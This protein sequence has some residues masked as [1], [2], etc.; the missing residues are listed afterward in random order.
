MADIAGSNGERKEFIAVGKPNVPGKLSHSIA[1][2][3]AKFGTDVIV[4]NMLHAKFMRSPYAHARVK[5]IDVSKAKAIPGIVE[6]ITCFDPEIKA[7]GG[8]AGMGGAGGGG[9]IDELGAPMLSD[10]AHMEDEEV[11]AIVIAENE[12]ACDEALRKLDI[13]WEQLPFILDP[14]EGKKPEAK[15]IRENKK[16]N[17][18][19][20]NRN[21]GN[22]EYGFKEADQIIEFDWN[23]PYYSSHI[24]NPAGGVAWWYDDPLHSEGE[25]I[26]IEG[27]TQGR[28]H[29][30]ALYKLPLDKVTENTIFQGGKY[31]DWGLRKAVMVTPF[32]S[33]RMGRPVRMVSSRR[34][35]Y[36]LAMNQRF[37]HLKVGFKNDGTITA[38]RDTAVVAAGIP[39]SSNFGTVMDFNYG[40]FF[41]T[42]CTN[43]Q[44]AWEAVYT[45]TGKMYLSAQ[46]CPWTWDSMTVAHQMIAEKLGMDPIDV[47]TKNIHGP[48]A[49]TDTSIPPSYQACV[50]TGKK[51]IK[52]QWHAAG[53]KKLPDGRLHGASF[54]YQM[55]PRHAF[56]GYSCT[57]TVKDDGKVYMPSRGP[58]TGMFAIDAIALVVAEEMGAKIE[59]VI[60]EFDPRAIFTPVGG[61]SDGTTA[62]AWVAKEAAVACKKLLLQTAADSLKV[63][64]EELDTKDTKVIFKSDPN[65]AFPFQQFSGKDLAATFTGRP[66]LSLWSQGMGKLLD[67]MNVLFCEVAVDTETGEVEVL[68]HLIVAD[69]GKV[70][71]RTSLEGQL[72]QVMI[73][74]E[75]NQLKE[76]FYFDK[77]TGVKLHTNMFE[78]KKPTIVDVGPIDSI[79]LE[80]R[81]GNAAYGAN[82]ISH[83]LA[84]THAII[85]AIHNAIGK[86]VDPPATPDR[87]LKALGKA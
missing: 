9:I 22:V 20:A 10:T 41:T 53:A 63:K 52:W 85:C 14:R 71:R 50:E 4:P 16:S 62:A 33:K 44:F 11:G 17:V 39:Y 67:T 76:D 47:A 86:W 87:I 32:L 38:V 6:I 55:C 84:N 18:E 30:A 46:H 26:W 78:Y 48:A 3:K 61:G 66:P 56:S 37:A 28:S 40:P 51:E 70:L 23:L 25:S 58:V 5:S 68:R 43:L 75:G 34:N 73:F 59:D 69:P 81:A 15:I 35:M 79:L 2:G 82:G 65:K 80:T 42:K 49:Q 45:N 27:A 57:V 29:I 54:R 13:V 74:S 77:S 24:P 1:T 21:E 31:C 12:D 60:V 83:S 64:P 72:H 19:L 7:L 8:G 36:D